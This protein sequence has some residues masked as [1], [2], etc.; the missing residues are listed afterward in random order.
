MD[1]TKKELEE[2]KKKQQELTE[3]VSKDKEAQDKSA[4]QE[5]EMA[6]LVK[7]LKHKTLAFATANAKHETDQKEAQVKQ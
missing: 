6:K 7:E 2:N 3:Q 5:E 4:K 1:A